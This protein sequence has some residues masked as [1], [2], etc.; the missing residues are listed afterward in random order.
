MKNINCLF[1]GDL[2]IDIIMNI[3]QY[4]LPGNESTANKTDTYIGGSALNSA[5][6]FAKLGNPSFMMGAMGIDHWSEII[7]TGLRDIAV[8]LSKV[9]KK[10]EFSTG[11]NFIPITPDGERTMFG[12]RGANKTF[13]P[14]D[15]DAH[16]LDKIDLVHISGYVFLSSP[17][18]EAAWKLVL[19]AEE[20][21]I[22]ISLDTTYEVASLYPAEI[23]RL[24]P[25]LTIC[26]MGIREAQAIF[27]T[28]DM[29]LIEDKLRD[30][31]INLSAI[32]MGSKGCLLITKTTSIHFPSFSIDPIDTTGAGDAF[33][34]GLI[35]SW[36]HNCSLNTVG[37]LSSL[38]GALAVSKPGAGVELPG[39]VEIRSNLH[40]I[41]E[42]KDFNPQE[43]EQT[44][45]SM[46]Y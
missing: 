29:Q 5:I 35:T 16:A 7:E 32:K 10:S 21:N 39:K 19:M 13:S 24:L 26:S 38:L 17:Q 30:M 3:N 15:I 43:I 28:Q 23:H 42:L 41:G 25:K 14:E 4:P 1:L 40:R 12:N 45:S 44:L 34:A 18:K 31:N 9:K 33:C 2:N 46:F 6:V 36:I 27:E 20:R 11:F 22:P 37:A 8:D